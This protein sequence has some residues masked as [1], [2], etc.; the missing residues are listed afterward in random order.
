MSP[1]IAIASHQQLLRNLFS[2]HRNLCCGGELVAEYSSIAE[3]G[4]GTKPACAWDLLIIDCDMP[5]RPRAEILG[6]VLK[7]Q[8]SRRVALLTDTRGGYT[9]H[10]AIRFG[11]QGVLHKRDSLE[12]ME[13]A[14]TIILSGSFFISAQIDVEKRMVFDRILSDRELCVL[15][16]LAQGE[17]ASEIGRRLRIAPATILTHRRNIMAKLEVNSQVDLVNFA[18]S[19]GLVPLDRMLTGNVAG[20]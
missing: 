13:S 11:L 5:D 12:T 18:V 17:S 1:K 2:R 10:C 8:A 14:L 15:E 4:A 16:A 20:R 19:Q 6:T 9:A 3:I 7:E